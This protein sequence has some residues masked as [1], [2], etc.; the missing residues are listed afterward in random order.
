MR[1]TGPLEVLALDRSL[2]RAII[3]NSAETVQDLEQVVQQRVAALQSAQP[4]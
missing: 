1:A 4:P 3:A 2:F